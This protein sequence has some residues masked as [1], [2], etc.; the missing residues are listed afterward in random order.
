M[1]HA[2]TRPTAPFATS[3]QDPTHAQHRSRLSLALHEVR[4]DPGVLFV[5]L[6]IFFMTLGLTLFSTLLNK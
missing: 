6:V 2:P 1:A 5:V 3:G 4:S